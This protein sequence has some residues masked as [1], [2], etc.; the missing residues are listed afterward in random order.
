MARRFAPRSQISRRTVLRGLGT[1]IALPWLEAMG[2]GG[3]RAG[4][5]AFAKESSARP[6]VRAAWLFAPNG[7]HMPDWTPKQAGASF[8][9]PWIL[10][11][12]A[13]HR[14]Q[15]LVLS[16][17]AQDQAR[18]HGD[19][20]GD[21]AR[22][23]AVFLTGAHPVKTSGA[24]IRVG[25]SVDQAAAAKIGAKTRFPSLELG[26]EAG[27]Q[28]GGCDSGYSCAYSSNMSWRTPT[29][30]MLKEIN[31]RYVFERLFLDGQSAQSKEARERRRRRRASVLDFVREDA[32]RLHDRIGRG[33]RAKL[34]EYLTGV[35]ELER[36][37]E[38]SEAKRSAGGDPASGYELPK[39]GRVDVRTHI[40]TMADLMVLAFQTDTTRVSTFMLGNGGSN[41]LYREI[42]IR[43][44]HHQISHH[45]K[46]PKKIDMIRRINR[47]HVEQLAYL[48]DRLK[49]VKEGD[50]TLLD[51]TMVLY[52]SCIGDGNRHNHDDLP[53][54]LAGNAAGSIRSGRHVRYP[55]WTRLNDLYLSM[56]DRLGA[57]VP[58]LGDS[59]GSLPK[60]A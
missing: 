13:E 1:A 28:N 54:L 43:G 19:G 49:S 16:G 41:I 55:R 6:P 42:G 45:G 3:L 36:R 56:L 10:E 15:L 22:S 25:V 50:G 60:L 5:Q 58:Q 7:K 17:L 23:A 38:Q 48:L 35:R 59:T 8:D 18:A 27:A 39:N 32:G 37:I 47:F 24:G 29:T 26:I 31:P 9:L 44:R 52:G 53:V 40:R 2:G 21:H 4:A 46:D 20:P 34:D 30:P 14:E 12:L 11:P 33:D 51:N 57:D